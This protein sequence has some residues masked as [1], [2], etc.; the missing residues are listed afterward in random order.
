MWNRQTALPT[1][2]CCAL[3]ADLARFISYIRPERLKYPLIKNHETGEFERATWDEALD[4]IVAKFT[5]I[6]KKYGSDALAGFACSRSP[7]E[8]CYMLQKMVRCAFGTN[9]VDNCARVCHS[10]TVAGTLITTARVGDKVSP[11]ET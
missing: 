2:D 3:R 10:A 1:R 6:K 8:D 7:N 9:N 5:E 11:K 4:L